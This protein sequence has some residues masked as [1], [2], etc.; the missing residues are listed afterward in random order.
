MSL[1]S[2]FASDVE[3]YVAENRE[4]GGCWFFVHIPKTAG[5]SFRR[6]L[7]DLLRPNYN[8]H[9][10]RDRRD[11]PHEQ[12]IAD[13]TRTFAE[14][15]KER[16][17]RFAS[18]HVPMATLAE[19]VEGWRDLKLITMLR[20]PVKRMISDYRYQTTPAHPTHREFIERFPTF[21]SFLE[22]EWSRDRMF[23]FLRPSPS[24]TVDECIQFVV[25]HFAFVGVVEMYPLSFRLMT[26][27]VGCERGPRHHVRKTVETEHNRVEVTPE[28]VKRVRQLN[29]RDEAV[30]RYF[31]DRLRQVRGAV[32]AREGRAEQKATAA[33][34]SASG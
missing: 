21:E 20:D 2:L 29:S 3:R 22:M 19:L 32:L 27:L 5:S 4:S 15:L 30:Y 33:D 34:V 6:E 1:T 11:I 14:R 31:H 24:A 23:R 26:R 8:V 16:P 18:G 12:K 13:A 9:V 28:L 7:A 17:Y 10:S 25:E